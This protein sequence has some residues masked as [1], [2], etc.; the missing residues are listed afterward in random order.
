MIDILFKKI[1]SW[2]WIY[3][4]VVTFC[5][6][7]VCGFFNHSSYPIDQTAFVIAT[8]I[9]IIYMSVRVG[10]LFPRIDSQPE[11]SLANSKSND[12]SLSCSRVFLFISMFILFF[13]ITMFTSSLVYFVAKIDWAVSAAYRDLF[14]PSLVP[15]GFSLFISAAFLVIYSVRSQWKQIGEQIE[16]LWEDF[17][18]FISDKIY[19]HIRSD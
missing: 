16:A 19:S 17:G 6:M 14:V 12:W 18:K 13:S 15:F 1:K 5:S 11:K 4:M 8:P 3:I 7:I 2:F 10:T 9:V